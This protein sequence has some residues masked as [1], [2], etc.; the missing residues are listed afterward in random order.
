MEFF[1]LIKA[2]QKSGKKDAV[3]W[4]TAKSVARANLQLD[5]ALE[6]AGIEETGRG[7]DYAK[8]IRTDFPVYD[9]LPEEGAVDYTWCE[10]YELQNDDRTWLPKVTAENSD[11]KTA[12]TVD[13]HITTESTLPETAGITL[14]EHDDDSTLYPVVQMP[15]RKQLLSQFT[16]DVL[17]HHVTREEYEAIGALEMDT[18][19]SY[20][21]NLL[22]AAENC[23]E[24]K[25]YDTKDLWRYTDAIRKV[26]SQ[27][28]RHELALVLRFTRMWAAT[29]YIDR[30]ILVREWA[31]GNRISSVQ[32]TDSGTNADGGYVTDR[33]PDAHHTL[34][35]LDLEIACA[36]LPMDFNH[37]EIPGSILRRAKEIVTKKEEPWKSWSNIL[38]NQ[39]G[40]LGVNRTAIFN[41]VRIAP[42]NIH[43]TPVAH[44]EFVNQTMTAAFNSAVELLPLHEAEPAAQEIPQP[45]GKESPRKSFCTHE[46]NLQRVREEGARRRAEEAA[47]QPQKVE[48]ELVKNVGNGIFDVTAL[49]QNSATHGTK[50]ATETTSNVQVQETVSDEKQAGDEVQPGESSLESGEESDT[51]QKDDV[52]QNTDSVAKNSDSV[53]QTEPVAAQTEPEAQSDEPAV[54]YPAYFEPGRYEGLPNEVYHAANG[55]SSTQVKDARVSLMYFNARHVEKTIVKERSAVL[56]MGNLVHALALQPELL[57]AEFSVE[58]VIPEGAFT[59][60]ATLRAFID[61]HNASLPALLSADDIKVLLEEYNATLPPQVPLGANLE[62]TAQNY[63][64]LP[65]DFQRI[66][67]DQKQTATAMKACIKEYNATLP[68][69]VKTSGSRDALLEQLAIINPDLVAQEA[70]K[71]APLKVSGTKADMIQ[72]VKAVKPDAVFADELLDAWRDNPEGKVLVTRQQLSTALNIQKALLAHPTAGMLLTHPSR[73]VEVSYFGFDEETGLEVRVRPD[74]EIDLDGVRIGADLKTISM[75]N[76]KQESLRARLHRE[77][78][79]RDYHLSAAM[80]CETAALDQFFWIFVNKDENYHW[81]AIIEASAELL[82]LGMLEYRKAMRNIA[83]GFDTGE[84]P[85]PIT[86]DYTDELNDFDLRRLEALRTQA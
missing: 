64:A 73:A 81:I 77:I 26:F 55:I 46:E 10:R 42:E 53:S 57:D 40:V 16:A 44:L 45:E 56:D 70:Q 2:S 19:N 25:G 27:D 63:M 8:P 34:D 15:F 82:E 78:I 33:G 75:W 30:G 24:V 21:Q 84:W 69:P 4:F 29:D 67:G 65:A 68:P 20:V 11:E 39:P 38:R 17:R 54:V 43:L 35:T 83:T 50:K 22:L 37:F 14:D 18:D 36:L 9:D 6:E 48:Q 13:S 23:P 32:R 52:N 7:K 5:V 85:A 66:D 74:L 41:L 86:A 47:A 49:L 12:Q 60:A 1:H 3:I 58:P 80:Y 28:K 76:V 51:S 62:E 79:E 71:P 31:A 59:T 61:E 72:A